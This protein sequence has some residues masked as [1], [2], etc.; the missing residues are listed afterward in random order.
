[1]TATLKT[2]VIQEPSS[3]I[4]NLTLSS[5]GGV[6]FG[7]AATTNTITSAASTALT[8]QSAGTTAMTIDTSQN[9]GIGTTTPS[10]KLD[11]IGGI[12][13][14]YAGAA[15]LSWNYSGQYL[16]WI[17]CGGTV[18]NTYMRFAT[19]NAEAMR[20]DSSGNLLVGTTTA[21]SGYKISIGN[22]TGGTGV[23]GNSN[24]SGVAYAGTDT[25]NFPSAG[26]VMGHITSTNACQIR[27]GSSGGVTLT[28]GATSWTSLSDA[29]LK[30]VTGSFNNA[31]IDIAQIQ[32][33]KFTWKDDASNKPC[34]GVIAQ[35]V[36]TVVPEAVEEIKVAKDD[37]TDYLSV[38]YTELIPIMIAA[39]QELSAKVDAQAAEITALKAKVG[40]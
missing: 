21:Q 10:Y 24:G 26:F 36:Q 5:S 15:K 37:E 34:V 6:T 22:G 16:N 11:V 25:V 40:A 18:G 8:I 38:K 20:I 2:T 33:V 28:S 13:I 32:A 14:S 39:I 17:E 29:R 1:M 35:S 7:A 9:V 27:T 30:N 23:Y 4:A 31:L 19:G 3:S 12:G